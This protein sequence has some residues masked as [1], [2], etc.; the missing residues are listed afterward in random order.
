MLKDI[1]RNRLLAVWFVAVGVIIAS[2]ALLG[3]NL[4]GS[5]TAF[6]LTLSLVPPALMLLLWRNAEPPTAREI[7]YS[8]NTPKDGRS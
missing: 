4:A 5:T 1:T 6:L 2:L 7:M 3:V 8:A